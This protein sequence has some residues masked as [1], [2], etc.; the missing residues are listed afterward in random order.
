MKNNWES[1]FPSL[2][3][4]MVYSNANNEPVSI[5]SVPEDMKCIGIGTD[6]AVFQSVDEPLYA[7]KLYASDKVSKLKVEQDIYRQLGDSI[8]FTKCYASYDNLLVL[9]Y[10]EGLTLFDCLLQG[11]HIPNQVVKDVDEA[12]EYVRGKGLNPRDI[13]LKNILLQ[14]GRAK[15]IDVSEYVQPGDDYRWKHLKR[16]YEEYYHLVDEKSI[17]FWVMETVRKWYNQSKK[18]TSFEEFMKVVLKLTT[19][20]KH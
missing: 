19:F 20:T 11:I 10:E 3:Q 5:H 13:H 15:I 6:A 17:P 8:F 9:R 16:A 14:N 4:I 1:A 12:R 18:T 7:Y 2:S